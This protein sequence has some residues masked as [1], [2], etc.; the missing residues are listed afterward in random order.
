MTDAEWRLFAEE[1]PRT[2]VIRHAFVERA[3]L[4]PV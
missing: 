2:K 4:K 3:V 1:R